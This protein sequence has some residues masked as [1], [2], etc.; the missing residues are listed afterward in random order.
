M[1][2]MTSCRKPEAGRQLKDNQKN[3]HFAMWCNITGEYELD[4]EGK[5]HQFI[6]QHLLDTLQFK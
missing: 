6:F 3:R 5:R 4:E 1:T 2:M